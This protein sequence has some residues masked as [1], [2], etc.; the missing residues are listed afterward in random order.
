[1][2]LRCES[3]MIALHDLSKE[4][5]DIAKQLAQAQ[6]NYLSTNLLDARPASRSRRFLSVR[7]FLISVDAFCAVSGKKFVPV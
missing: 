2:N 6:L 5:G 4:Q 7:F 3:N 1:M